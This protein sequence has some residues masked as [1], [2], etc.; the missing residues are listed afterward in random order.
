MR[1]V[2]KLFWCENMLI[3]VQIIFI[4]KR[5]DCHRRPSSGLRI[6]GGNTIFQFYSIPIP[7]N[8]LLY[9]YKMKEGLRDEHIGVL[10]YM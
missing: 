4:V 9:G 10:L 6:S 1:N 2:L 3:L 8:M 5:P 7:S